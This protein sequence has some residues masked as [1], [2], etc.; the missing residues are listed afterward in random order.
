[1]RGARGGV[2]C[3][4]HRIDALVG[5]VN[6]VNGIAL[7]SNLSKFELLSQFGI[8]RSTY[9]DI[10][11]RQLRQ[12]R[13]FAF[14]ISRFRS[15]SCSPA[16]PRAARYR[17]CDARG[18]AGHLGQPNRSPARPGTRADRPAAGYAVPVHFPDRG[19]A[20]RVLRRMSEP[21]APVPMACQLSPGLATRPPPI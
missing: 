6:C 13:L 15:D 19:L 16:C 10:R 8:G 5:L 9:Y 12:E 3:E 14:S 20:A 2:T 7:L 1:M 18:S 17:L 4:R 11:A 21:P